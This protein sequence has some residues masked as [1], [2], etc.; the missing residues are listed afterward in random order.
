[1]ST[2]S[3]RIAAALVSVAALLLPPAA[4]S[5]ADTQSAYPRLRVL[6]RDDA[7]YLQQQAELDQF[8]QVAEA[9]GPGGRAYPALS[10][11]EYS[12]RASDD[13]FALNAR[14]GLRYDTLA[15]LNGVTDRAAFAT[16]SVILVPTQDGLFVNNPPQGWIEG[17]IVADRQ[18]EGVA[19]IPLVV[20]RAGKRTPLLYYPNEAFS[21]TERKFFLGVLLRAPVDLPRVSSD[22]GWRADPFTGQREFHGGVDLAAPEGSKVYA[23]RDGKVVEVNRNATL[24]NYIILAH[25]GGLQTVYGHLSAVR[26]IMNTKVAAGAVIGAV[27]HTG[28][29]TGP[30]LHFE[31]RE[32]GTAMNPVQLLAMKKN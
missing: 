28:Y 3:R 13:L 25:E 11:F 8:R 26:V 6:T 2:R 22:F 20:T 17:L 4:A 31:V 29:A 23:A 7:L 12:R 9:R 18:A 10:L 21:A 1:V 15:T 27:G 32:N 19:P 30:H 14:L 5:A 24:G 16:L